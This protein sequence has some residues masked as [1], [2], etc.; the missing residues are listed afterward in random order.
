MALRWHLEH[1]VQPGCVDRITA[2][3]ADYYRRLVGFGTEFEQQVR[4]GLSE[5]CAHADA[6]ECALWLAVVDDGPDAPLDVA[7]S[8][9]HGSIAIDA[10]H[11]TTRGAHLRWFIAS[12]ALRGSGAGHALLDAALT[13]CDA[14]GYAGIHLW[15]F[16]R[17]P[18]ARHLYEK[19]GFVLAHGQVGRRWGTEVN[20]QLF[21]RGRVDVPAVLQAEGG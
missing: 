7:P 18:A 1:G 19:K 5:F 21:V 17:L 10:R 3:H 6:G 16:D 14:R 13:F 9:I 20:E 15:T 8:R 2:L 12:D 11:A 4:S